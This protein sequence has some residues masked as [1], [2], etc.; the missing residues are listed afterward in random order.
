MP[1]DE[2]PINGP[3]PPAK[4][5]SAA[6]SPRRQGGR[7]RVSPNISGAKSNAEGTAAIAGLLSSNVYRGNHRHG[8]DEVAV[9]FGE[10][11]PVA[12]DEAQ[13]TSVLADQHLRIRLDD[14]LTTSVADSVT[15]T[16]LTGTRRSWCHAEDQNCTCQRSAGAEA[17]A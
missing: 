12:S 17:K 4:Y 16:A 6:L 5:F 15:P 8:L 9:A 2:W 1:K 7:D 10:R 13:V 3:T 14:L 11:P